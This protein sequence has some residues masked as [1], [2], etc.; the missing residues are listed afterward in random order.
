MKLFHISSKYLGEEVELIPKI[1][2]GQS[3]SELHSRYKLIPR[4]SCSDT[5]EKCLL[6][7]TEFKCQPKMFVYRPTGRFHID[8]D[9]ARHCC[10]DWETTDECWIVEPTKF[11]FV[12]AIEV[13]LDNDWLKYTKIKG[14]SNAVFQ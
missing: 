14:V 6:G 4:I 12:C 8:W 9:S 7:I 3:L 5:I 2:R 1:P 11:K 10:D 13:P